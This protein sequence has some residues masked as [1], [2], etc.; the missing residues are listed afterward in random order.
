M[1][2]AGGFYELM[3]KKEAIILRRGLKIVAIKYDI[4]AYKMKYIKGIYNELKPFYDCEI[5]ILF[6]L[7]LFTAQFTHL[8]KF[9]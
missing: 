1:K 6:W 9:K 4:D 5:P 7:E 2:K 8:R 3:Y